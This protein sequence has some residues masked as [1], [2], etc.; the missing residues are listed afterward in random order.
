M[1]K[2][3]NIILGV[4]TYDQDE[5]Q[6]GATVAIT[7]NKPVNPQN[8]YLKLTSFDGDKIVTIEPIVQDF[9]DAYGDLSAIPEGEAQHLHFNIS[10]LTPGEKYQYEIKA[11]NNENILIEN[12]GTEHSAITFNA[13]PTPGQQKKAKMILSADQEVMDLVHSIKLD[14]KGA[15][16]LGL[17][18]DQKELTT[19]IYQEIKARSPD[20]FL[21]AG[22]IMYGE[23]F[24][25]NGQVEK[26]A[27]FREHTKGDF[28]D[29][30]GDSLA[31]SYALRTLDDHDFGDNGA[32]KLKFE[33]DPRAYT[34]AINSFNEFWPVPSEVTDENRGLFY[35]VCFGDIGIWCL[36]NRIYSDEE[37]GDLLGDVQFNWLKNS[38]EASSAKAK[39]IMSPLPLVMGKNPGE[40]Y[41]ANYVYWEKIVNLAADARITA[42]LCADSHN[43]SRS[44]LK[45]KRHDNIVTIPQLLVGILGGKPQKLD[46]EE[47]DLLPTPLLPANIPEEKKGLYDGSQVKAYYTGM[48]KP[49]SLTKVDALVRG[50]KKHRAFQDGKWNGQEVSKSEFGFSELDIDFDSNKMYTSLFLMKRKES[51]KPHFEDNAEYPLQAKVES[52]VSPSNSQSEKRASLRKA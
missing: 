11:R 27:D 10:G 51:K 45:V 29:T 42:F 48:P 43:Y 32:S 28:H 31:G 6:S 4:P 3:S 34:N 16:L 38:L 25:P 21:H 19:D 41:R 12:T 40:D 15:K 5:N 26:L 35:E 37:N 22:D 2:I 36:N 23:N 33:A 7:F 1:A 17:Q 46:D 20:I 24:M 39:F 47:R 44:E 8:I 9:Q 50:H 14:D 30:V 18:L 13:A 49:G 52:L